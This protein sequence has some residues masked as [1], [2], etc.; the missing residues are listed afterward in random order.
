MKKNIMKVAIGLIV[1]LS[2]SAI[3]VFAENKTWTGVV[4]DNLCIQMDFAA[5]GADM[6][7]NPE[8]HTTYCALMKP[9]IDSGYS[10]MVKNGSGGYDSYPL[11]TKGNKLALKYFENTN[12]KDNH[13][14]QVSGTILSNDTIKVKRIE[15]VM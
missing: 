1:L 2:V 3:P 5:D 7:N 10:V 15:E 6:A 11:D 4:A 8:Q 13:I 9:C 12:K 14:L